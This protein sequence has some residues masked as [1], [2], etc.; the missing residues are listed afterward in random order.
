MRTMG[1]GTARVYALAAT[2]LVFF[3]LWSAISARPWQVAKAARDPR[4][5]ALTNRERALQRQAR[6]VKRIV[7]RRWALYERRLRTRRLEIVAAEQRHAQAVAAAR[8]A[9]YRAWAATA[10]AQATSQT[11]ASVSR[12]SAAGVAPAGA[13][14]A[15]SQPS[16]PVPVSAPA[17]APTPAPPAVQVVTLPPVTS[18]H[19]SG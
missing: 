10:A 19:S 14:T 5:A 13:A 3:V 1:N 18:S 7:A 8:A 11:I 16:A 15:P 4:V 17:P 9:A 12:P 6:E 2:I